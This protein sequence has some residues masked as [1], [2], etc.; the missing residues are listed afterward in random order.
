MIYFYPR[1]SRVIY[2]FRKQLLRFPSCDPALTEIELAYKPTQLLAYKSRAM[3]ERFDES[4]EG[5]K[6]R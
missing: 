4:R 1:G 3:V 6:S 2:V 5:R